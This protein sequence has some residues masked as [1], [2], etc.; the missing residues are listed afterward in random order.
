LDT[1]ISRACAE[2]G[3]NVAV[4]YRASPDAPEVAAAIAKE[5][6]VKCKAY[7]LDQ[8]S[9]NV[10]QEFS[11]LVKVVE[12]D[13]GQ[14]GGLV[15]NAGVTSYKVATEYS[16]E[17]FDACFDV[18][19]KGAFFVSQTM[20][21]IWIKRSQKNVSIV[22][23]S[24]MS[25]QIINKGMRLTVYH[26]SKAA[27]T[28]MSKSMAVEWAVHGI[29]VNILSPGYVHTDMN[30]PDPESRKFL[31]SCVPQNRFGLPEEQAAAAVFMLSERASYMTGVDMLVDG[32]TSLWS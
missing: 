6:G 8:G 28:H 31:E 26:G 32:G 21:K 25:G 3:A 13:L 29:R 1:A 15:V 14:V 22:V 19:V 23:N 4:V 27:I 20:A 18:N 2:A 7:Q 9:R 5:F 16:Y 11:D 30:N 24:S 10:V 17:D 12:A